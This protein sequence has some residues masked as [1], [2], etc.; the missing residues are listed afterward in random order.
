M[1][2]D[3]SLLFSGSRQV[4]KGVGTG[5]PTGLVGLGMRR[6]AKSYDDG[7][8]SATQTS[9]RTST[10]HSMTPHPLAILT[11]LSSQRPEA[12]ASCFEVL[13]SYTTYIS[14]ANQ[15]DCLYVA[16]FPGSGVLALSGA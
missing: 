1:S 11:I 5:H 12:Q 15:V 14:T 6:T 10:T 9:T 7:S 3:G 16:W 8:R 13:S 4:G 2:R